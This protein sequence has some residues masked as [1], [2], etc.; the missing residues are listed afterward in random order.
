MMFPHS[1]WRWPSDQVFEDNT[2][3][4]HINPGRQVVLS[5]RSRAFVST[6]REFYNCLDGFTE[7]LHK[8]QHLR[9]EHKLRD[10]Q[11]VEELC[12]DLA[13][14]GEMILLYQRRVAQ[15]DLAYGFLHSKNDVGHYANPRHPMTYAQIERL[16]KDSADFLNSVEREILRADDFLMDYQI[17]L[18]DDAE[19]DILIARDLFSLGFDDV[20]LLVLGRALERIV[21]FVLR[22]RKV[23]LISGRNTSS[24]DTATLHDAIETLRRLRWKRRGERFLNNTIVQRLQWLRAIRNDEVH[25]GIGDDGSDPRDLGLLIVGAIRSLYETHTTARRRPLATTTITRDW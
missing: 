23:Q 10:N 7:A 17:D 2:D 19:N 1:S 6:L 16:I 13:Y 21:R 3:P 5:W 8:L 9:Q 22:E 25:Q 4:V 14:N 24:A 15:M 12:L 11:E 20:G 18:P